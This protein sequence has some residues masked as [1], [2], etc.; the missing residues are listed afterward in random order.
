MLIASLKEAE[1]SD[2]RR[3]TTSLDTLHMIQNDTRLRYSKLL[4]SQV[5]LREKQV[6]YW[7]Y[8]HTRATSSL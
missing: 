6:D 7:L 3:H 1:L 2:A 5:E 8:G 4:V